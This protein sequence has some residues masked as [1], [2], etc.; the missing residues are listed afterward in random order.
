[1]SSIKP[2]PVLATLIN[3]TVKYDQE[4]INQILPHNL[5]Y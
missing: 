5:S 2:Q 4:V 3:L 1:M